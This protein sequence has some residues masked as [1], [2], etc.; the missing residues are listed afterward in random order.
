MDIDEDC[1]P[2]DQPVDEKK[3]EKM[4]DNERT[5]TIDDALKH[6]G[7]V[8]KKKISTSILM[9]LLGDDGDDALKGIKKVHNNSK[10]KQ[11]RK[12][13]H[14]HDAVEHFEGKMEKRRCNLAE[15]IKL[16]DTDSFARHELWW[17]NEWRQALEED[18]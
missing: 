3:W 5:E 11:K 8:R 10:R 4:T 18:N 14:V 15:K 17:R 2:N 1:S 9:D 6:I 12:M 16:T 7:N 13:D